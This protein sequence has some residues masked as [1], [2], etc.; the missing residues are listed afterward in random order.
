MKTID[1]HLHIIEDE[2]LFGRDMTFTW[3]DLEAY[4]GVV[5]RVQLMPAMENDYDSR[6]VN[7]DFFTKLKGFRL[8]KQVWG[9]YWPHPHEVDPDIIKEYDVAGIKYHPSVSQLEI[10]KATAVLDLAEDTGLPLVVHCGRNI[11]SRIEY[12]IEA[13]KKKNITLIAAHLGGVSPPLISRALQILENM[14]DFDHFYLD[15]SSIDVSRLIA[16]AINVVGSERIL[17]GTDT[18]FHEYHVLKYA[19]QQVWERDDVKISSQDMKNIMYAN[20]ERIHGI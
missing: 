17:F 10:D 3:E 19:M 5:A 16:R 7:H 9:F 12:C 8:N 4:L 15:T 20:V 13:Y 11:K 6:Q 14:N 1:S 2:N 18:P